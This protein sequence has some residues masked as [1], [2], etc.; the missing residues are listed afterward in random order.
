MDLEVEEGMESIGLSS[1]RIRVPRVIRLA[2]FNKVPNSVVKFSRQ[3]VMTRD[4]FTCCYCNKRK[5][6]SNLSMDHVVPRSKGGRTVWTNI[7]ACCTRC[8]A[9]KAD[10]TPHEAGMHLSK[11]PHRPSWHELH[12]ASARKNMY[13]EW[14]NF[15]VKR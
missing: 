5:H 7:V 11:V 1:K 13:P 12:L 2:T 9:E 15:L 10:R 4:N 14:E 8:N 3:N 6:I